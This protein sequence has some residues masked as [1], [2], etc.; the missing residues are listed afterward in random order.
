[1]KRLLLSLGLLVGLGVLGSFAWVGVSHAA[2]IR[3]GDAP[4]VGKG[5]TIDGSVYIG[6][7]TV[8]IDGTVKGDVFCAGLDV[9]VNGTVEGDVICAGRTVRV[10]GKVMGDVRVA[11]QQVDVSA[12]VAGSA[13]LAG[14][15]LSMT[16]EATIGRDVTLGVQ[17][18]RLNGTIGRDLLGGGQDVILNA[19]IGRNALIDFQNVALESK[20]KI[21]GDL[22]Y[23]S[24]DTAQ[25]DDAAT[26][27]GQTKHEVTE[28][29]TKSTDTATKLGSTVF[30]FGSMLLIGIFAILV[31]PR[32]FDVVGASVRTRPFA[33]FAYGAAV[34]FGV[35][36]VCGLLFVTLIGL[37]LAFIL[38]LLWIAA[39]ISAMTITAYALG[40]IVVEKLAWPSRGQRIASLLVGL[41]FM[42]LIGLIPVI[43][44]IALFAS[45]LFGLGSL[46][47]TLT[48]KLRPHK[49]AK[50]GAKA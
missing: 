4:S 48:T 29:D 41:L 12:T 7:R 32:W 1:M 11:G 27:T 30:G 14:E 16:P 43:G 39:M 31:A 22:T 37:P 23:R 28:R 50:K 40:W 35:P 21:G 20:T 44:G 49:M 15:S 45:L 46:A 2:D 25:K 17:S 38:L 3:S 33:S 47:I 6:G 18:V 8:T 26:V 10:S 19:T 34:L 42:A 13:T 9:Y 24:P 36:M 5:E